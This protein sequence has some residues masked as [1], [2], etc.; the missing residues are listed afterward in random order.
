MK[1]IVADIDNFYRGQTLSL[2]SVNR[3]KEL[4]EIIYEMT[5]I[6]NHIHSSDYSY[7]FWKFLLIDYI[8]EKLQNKQV[9]SAGIENNSSQS[10]TTAK[11]KLVYLYK[12]LSNFNS[13]SKIKKI[14]S[15]E[16]DIVYGFHDTEIIEREVGK[17]M[18][19]YFPIFKGSKNIAKRQRANKLA[20]EY[21]DFFYKNLI[22]QLPEILVERFDHI[23]E[24]IPLHDPK[25]KTFHVSILPSEFNTILIAKYVRHGA[26]LH[27][28]QHGGG[29]GEINNRAIFHYS[30]F[31]DH[32]VTW[33]W[34]I[35]ETEIP[36]K[37]YRCHGFKNRY[38][39]FGK[40]FL[41]DCAFVFTALDE[42]YKNFFRP[43]T[44]YIF[45]NLDFGKYP[46]VIARPRPLR[47]WEDSRSQLDFIK[48]E[49]IKIDSGKTD[50]AYIAAKSK[51]VVT[52]KWIWPQ[53]I[54]AE[55]I[56]V[57]HP[58]IAM[59]ADLNCT[60]I[61]KPYYDFFVEQKVFHETVESLVDHLNSVD[62]D[63]WW[64]KLTEHPMYIS[65]KHT[66]VRKVI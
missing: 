29:G 64:S 32:Y 3:I 39:K 46:R 11:Q 5:S 36:G 58:I 45:K 48:H 35:N 4:E 44:D 13:F 63:K 1:E 59:V 60:T 9:L 49:K 50:M 26:K 43:I 33:G 47:K 41:Y 20:E 21:D 56:Y 61:F 16:K 17:V 8:N 7:K 6:M 12:F 14:L 62:L 28:Y 30:S 2:E 18:P 65:Y 55:C 34:K 31:S 25:G 53:T 24:E 15:S 51:I 40:D 66:F 54:F 23:M 57:D 52:F 42:H 37:A 38:N 19:S 10:K 22:L 27:F